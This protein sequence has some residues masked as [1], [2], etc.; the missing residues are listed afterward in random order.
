MPTN[1]FDYVRVDLL[2]A[3][4]ARS[5]PPS[6]LRTLERLNLSTAQNVSCLDPLPEQLC[7][8]ARVLAAAHAGMPAADLDALATP[9][10]ARQ[11]GHEVDVAAVNLLAATIVA[12]ARRHREALQRC[13]QAAKEGAGGEHGSRFL[14]HVTVLLES[15]LHVLGASLGSVRN[16]C[17]V[18]DCI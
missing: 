16:M 12:A 10:Q 11:M 8:A 2:D 5:W 6:A 13:A 15:A 14:G 4:S 17:Q 1:P 3:G 9:L 7:T 18:S